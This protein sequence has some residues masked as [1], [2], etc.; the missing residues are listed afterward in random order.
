MTPTEAL[1]N[2]LSLCD[3]LHALALEENRFLKQN[4][5]VPD[6]TL[7]DR[8]RALLARL[9]ESVEALKAVSAQKQDKAT[10]ERAKAR[11]L[12]ILHLD[13]ENEQLLL[14]YSLG[15][16]SPRAAAP[17]SPPPAPSQ[18]QRLYERHS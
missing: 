17:T 4:Q 8:K 7:L 12:Q 13:R 3:E 15:V 10:L 2:H 6:P 16:R 11:I 1:Q 9:D 18:L 5:R 14:R